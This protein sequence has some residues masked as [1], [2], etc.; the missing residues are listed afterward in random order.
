MTPG[1]KI[2][3]FF[4]SI[5]RT[6]VIII[7]MKLKYIRKLAVVIIIFILGLILF[8][9]TNPQSAPAALLIVPF[10]FLYVVFLFLFNAV[11]RRNIRSLR[12][13]NRR[14]RL[15][16]AGTI[17]A[18]P[19]IILALQSIGQLTT[20]DVVTLVILIVVLGFYVTRISFTKN[21]S[22]QD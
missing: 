2:W 6:Y 9:A 20:R 18:L 15:A 13:N 8:T 17:A 5:E 3:L 7:N 21:T 19:V 16:I 10:I 4:C 14:K 1:T 11:L 22:T 12:D